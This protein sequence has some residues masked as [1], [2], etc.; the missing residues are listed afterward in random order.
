MRTNRRFGRFELSEVDVENMTVG[1]RKVM[2]NVLILRAEYMFSTRTFEYSA[3]SPLFRELSEGE[4]IP[5]YEFLIGGNVE[6][7]PTFVSVV[8][9]SGR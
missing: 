6:R 1:A 7:K 4:Q 3:L 5:F 9:V 8:E 2:E